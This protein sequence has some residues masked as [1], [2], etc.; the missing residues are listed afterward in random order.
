M[1]K[2]Q[3]GAEDGSA[4]SEVNIAKKNNDNNEG[5]T[6]VV[7]FLTDYICENVTESLKAVQQTFEK[8]M[9]LRSLKKTGGNQRKAAKILGIKPTTLNN[10]IRKYGIHIKKT[11]F[12]N[13]D[14]DEA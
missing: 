6:K 5:V 9:I 2:I 10:K 12:L 3:P 13:T 8:R 4:E 14:G 1:I 7:D 11:L